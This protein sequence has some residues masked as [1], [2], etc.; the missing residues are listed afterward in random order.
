MATVTVSVPVTGTPA[1]PGTVSVTVIGTCDGDRTVIRRTVI[2]TSFSV[3]A[4]NHHRFIR[5]SAA[6]RTQPAAARAGRAR[7]RAQ[8]ALLGRTFT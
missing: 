6:R 5:G 8:A 2:G 7:A 4:S 3:T 1:S